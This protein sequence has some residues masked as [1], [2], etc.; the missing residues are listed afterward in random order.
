MP[1]VS[2]VQAAA[3]AMGR[4]KIDQS[5]L[6]GFDGFVDEI[7]HL[8]DERQDADHFTRINSMAAYGNRVANA[9]GKSCN[10]EMVV[11]QM[12]LGGNGPIMGNS[13]Q[14]QGYKIIY[15]GALGKERIHPVFEK[16]ASNCFKVISCAD[17]AHTDALEFLDGKVMMG[18][19][20]PLRDVNWTQLMTRVSLD[21]MRKIIEE[22][23]LVACTNWTMLPFMNSILLG[24]NDVL[25]QCREKKSVFVDLADP[26]KRTVVDIREVLEL[27]GSMQK[28]ADMLL[29]L[30]E[31]EATQ[32]ARVL[33]VSTGLDLKALA[34]D[35]RS[36]TG[37][38]MVVIHP[39]KEAAVATGDGAFW[40]G[41]PY[42]P[43]PKLT[44]G[45][46]DNFNAGFCNGYLGGLPA[47]QCLATGVCASGFYVRNGRSPQHQELVEFMKQWAAGN[48]GVIE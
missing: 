46:G 25:G 18:K 1:Q 22:V 28:V 35:I 13:L 42:T 6:V 16:F 27:L 10:V 45:A 38:H 19:L 20:Q 32:I 31:D 34:A 17:P 14:A 30:N 41:G 37:L 36:K 5:I 44:T 12:K 3:E 21:E 48:C 23:S 43:V 11:N 33:G 47:E 39:V 7:I 4:R 29:G 15:M 9:A 26:R 24:L 2:S 8:V 40:M